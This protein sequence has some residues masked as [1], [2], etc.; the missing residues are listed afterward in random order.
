SG[1]AGGITR[2][3]LPDYPTRR[4]AA[5]APAAAGVATLAAPAAPPAAAAPLP[6]Y[7]KAAS[8]GAPGTGPREETVPFSRV[9]RVIAENMV[10]A[11]HT[12]AHTH[13]FDECDM[14]A[15][16]SLRKEWAP[17]LEAQGTKLTYMPFFIKAAVF[18]LK[19]FPWVNGSVSPSGDAMILKH[20]YNIGM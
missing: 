19:E 14:G 15:I 4:G 11:K 1:V 16:V 3:D 9:R 10:K 2:D 6:A 13:C 7:M 17:K 8:L 12:A 18:A 5:A 20:Y